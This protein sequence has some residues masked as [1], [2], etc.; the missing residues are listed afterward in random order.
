VSGPLSRIDEYREA[1]ASAADREAYLLA[2]SGLPGLRGNLELARV[3]ADLCSTAELRRWARLGADEARTGTAEEFLAFAGVL[4]LGGSLVK[5]DGRALEE[6]RRHASDPR[7]RIREAVAM[8]LQRWGEADFEALGTA[9]HE[10]AQGTSLE[11]RA[12]AAALC[13]PALLT[14]SVRVGEALAVL[15]EATA[16]IAEAGAEERRSEEFRALR[17]GLGYCWSVAV[18]AGPEVGRPAFEELVSWAGASDDRDLAWVARANL[19][20]RRLERLDLGWVT[21]LLERL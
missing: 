15:A 12:A 9:M 6:L 18:A 20:K 7:W 4:G 14:T 11:R 19:R 8:A 1:L 16:G 3:A 5:G 10:W 13:E 17:K 2:H 21:R